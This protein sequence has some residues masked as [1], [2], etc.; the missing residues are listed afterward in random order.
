MKI[1]YVG[2][3]VGWVNYDKVIEV[4]DLVSGIRPVQDNYVNP[5]YY[6]SVEL[7]LEIQATY[8]MAMVAIDHRLNLPGHPYE[9]LINGK[10]YVG[11]DLLWKLGAEKLKN[12]ESFF[13]PSRLA[14]LKPSDVKDW[15]G[16]VWDYGVRA[17]LLSD[18]GV[19]ITSLF[20]S[21]T[22]SALRSTGGRLLGAGGLVELM[23]NFTAYTDPVEK[24]TYLLAKFIHG[25]GI[26]RFTDINN[27]QV[28]V[29]NHLTRIAIRLGLVELNQRFM[30]MVTSG[31]PFTP[32][33]DV[34]LRS[35]VR[36]SWKIVSMY[37][38]TDAFS[39]DDYLWNLGRSVCIRD[40]PNCG[41]CQL[42]KACNAYK[43]GSFINEHVFYSTFWY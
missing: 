6:P 35:L 8:F 18:L 28:A 40:K 32:K 36:D 7:D 16:D 27:A 11:S 17:F 14:N 19:K 9:A 24:K 15:L 23:R 3:D 42:R 37:S 31:I 22:L 33:D 29:D 26:I 34:N 5:D 20:N 4:A 13:T 12:D 2:N 39:L 1:S 30:N 38:H 25:R 41:K 21:S 10:S 43:S